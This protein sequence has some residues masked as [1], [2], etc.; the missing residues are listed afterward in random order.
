MT[1][2][3]VWTGVTLWL[4]LNAAIAVRCIYVTRPSEIEAPSARIIHLNHHR[5]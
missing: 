1:T 2:T 4:G 5:A 3:V